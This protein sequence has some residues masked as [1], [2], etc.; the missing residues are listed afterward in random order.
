VIYN[1][2]NGSGYELKFREV[3]VAHLLD[4]QG[5]STHFF[6]PEGTLKAVNDISITIEEGETL[7]LVGESGC[8]K[9]MTAYSVLRL[10]PQPGR[11]VAGT[12]ALDGRDLLSLP[13]DKIRSLRGNR[14]AMVFQEPMTSL[15]P[16]FR[17]GDQIT[18][19]IAAHC[20]STSSSAKDR[21][22]QLLSQVGIPS[23]E[24]RITAY[25]H[26]LSGG[27]R[28]RVMIAMAIACNPRL[29]IADEPTTALDVTIQ[30]QIMT[31]LDTLKEKNSMGMLLITH[32]MGLVAEHSHRTAVMYAGRIVEEGPT[33]DILATPLHPYTKGLLDSLPQRNTP[34]TALKTIPGNLP[35]L[36]STLRGC[37]FCDRCPECLDR[38]RDELPTLRSVAANRKVRCWRVE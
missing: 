18:E 34:G 15:N 6:L 22:I 17:I 20:T 36:N 25:P 10:V 14:I 7:A 1:P 4:I 32:D 29:L 24:E 33:S 35:G 31:L 37:A 30:A 26:E 12:I 27:M 2:R 8:G 21:A 13:E 5:L 19:V 9:S 28:Q 23:P 16:V 38:C 3:S 11:I